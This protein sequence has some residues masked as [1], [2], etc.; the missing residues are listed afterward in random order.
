MSVSAQGT[1]EPQKDVEWV[2]GW[3]LGSL[4]GASL[5]SNLEGPRLKARSPRRAWGLGWGSGGVGWADGG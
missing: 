1:G 3:V 4:S 5:E 2:W